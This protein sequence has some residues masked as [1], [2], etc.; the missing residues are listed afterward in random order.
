M[1]ILDYVRPYKWKIFNGFA[2]KFIGTVVE[3]LLPMMLAY[4]LDSVIADGTLNEII[5]FGVSMMLCAVV[6]LIL[7][8]IANRKASKVSSEI[9]GNIRSALFYKTL[10][11]SAKQ[12]DKFTIP[13]LEARIT[14]DTYN[15]QHFINAIQRI[16]VRAPILLVGGISMALFMDAVLALVMIATLPFIFAVT[17]F[18]SKNGTL[19][20]SKVQKSTDG[21]IRVVREDTQGI[22]VIKALSKNEY[23]NRRYGLKNEQLSNDEKR[24]GIIMG[25]PGPIMTLL[26]NLGICATIVLCAVR[27]SENLSSPTTV[28]AFMQYFSQITASLMAISRIFVMYT[29]FAASSKRVIEVLNAPDEFFITETAAKD[30]AKPAHVCFENVTFSYHGKT[31]NLKNV[32]F[33]LQKGENLGIIGA[34]GSGKST[35]IKL[36]M[37]FYEADSGSI[38]IKVSL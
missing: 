15:V 35:L 13:S 11:L 34:T 32:S 37:R 36:L 9:A 18:I 17:F 10:N 12:T 20:Y 25:I 21:M 38:F 30:D 8:V 7:N 23:E 4:M 1:S 16:G 14:T 22:R 6:A 2:I 24:V 28:I 3:L 29:K 19:L 26:M 27:V 31:P 33:S 5:F